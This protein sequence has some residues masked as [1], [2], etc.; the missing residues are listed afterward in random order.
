MERE[1]MEVKPG[2]LII[3]GLLLAIVALFAGYC[4]GASV[5]RDAFR[6][7]AVKE[8]HA[9]YKVV[10]EYGRTEFEWLPNHGPEK[11]LVAPSEKK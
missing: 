11:P 8:G 4:F 9:A 3:G 5:M 2:Y 7:I 1:S 10:D 6:A